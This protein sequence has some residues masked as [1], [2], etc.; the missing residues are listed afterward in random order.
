MASTK[1]TEKRIC[2]FCKKEEKE[3]GHLILG[4]DGVNICNNCVAI[5]ADI[6][7]SIL[8]EAEEEAKKAPLNLST[9]P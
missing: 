6:L 7:V 3:V 8:K 1:N 9:L 5:C 4:P 2:A